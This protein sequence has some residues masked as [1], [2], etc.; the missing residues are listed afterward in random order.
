MTMNGEDALTPTFT[1]TLEQ[2]PM[3]GDGPIGDIDFPTNRIWQYV[4]EATI[5]DLTQGIFAVTADASS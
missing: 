3:F 1:A 5:P 4:R 2:N